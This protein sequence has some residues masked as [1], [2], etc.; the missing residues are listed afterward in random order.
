METGGSMVHFIA[1]KHL[2]MAAAAH[3]AA[4]STAKAPAAEYKGPWSSL[5]DPA[6]EMGARATEE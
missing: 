6:P 3:A 5:A 1:H 2:R 4:R